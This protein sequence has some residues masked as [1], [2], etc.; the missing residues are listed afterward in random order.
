MTRLLAVI[1]R[2]LKKFKRNPVVLGMS[3]L[4]PIIYLVILG[5]SF[6]GKLTDLPLAV[7]SQDGGP[8]AKRVMEYLQAVQAGPRTFRI[9]ALDDEQAAVDG[10]RAGKYKAALIIPP[11]FSRRVAVRGRPDIG[12]FLDNTDSISSETIRNLVNAA[13]LSIGAEYVPVRERNDVPLLRDVNLYGKVDYYQSLVPGV[14]IMA[15]FLGTLTTGAFN[16]VMDRFLGIE[17]S[18]LLTPLSKGHIVGGL[19]ISGLSITTV[20]ALFIFAT[21]MLITGIPLS[22]GLLNFFPILLTVVLTTLCLLSLMFA[23][24]GRISHPRIV[25][26]LSGFLNVILFF[27]SGAVYPIASFPGW[28]KSFS[29]VNPE[30]YAVDAL[31]SILFKNAGMGNI[32][33]DLGFLALFTAA[34]MGLSIIT[35]KRTL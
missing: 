15:I 10:V 20:N 32:L 6:Q 9:V 5:N 13:L 35:F 24:L 33:G 25:G 29:K 34:L 8:Y 28:L 19:I 21:S 16:L 30:A 2:D 31:K 27:P 3:I 1:E 22:R 23:I 11:D 4:M 26:V 7:V 12:L 17:E 18:Y 14:V